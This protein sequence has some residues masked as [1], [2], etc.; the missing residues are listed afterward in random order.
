MIDVKICKHC[1]LYVT[2]DNNV[3]MCDTETDSAI[4]H[5]KISTMKDLPKDCPYYLEH[6]VASQNHA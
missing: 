6:L 4:V 1:D 2:G 3:V 5:F